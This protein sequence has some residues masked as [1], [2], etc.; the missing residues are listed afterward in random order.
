MWETK[1]GYRGSKSIKNNFIVKEKRV[2]GSCIKKLMLRGTLKDFE[3]NY[4][5]RILSNQINLINKR[6]YT[7]K[8]QQTNI[9][10]FS[11]AETSQ[12]VDTSLNP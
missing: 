5:L 4:Q 8:V 9:D 2:D 12:N 6:F 10:P 11:F 1:I 3:K 7:T